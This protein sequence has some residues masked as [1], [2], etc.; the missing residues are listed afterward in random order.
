MAHCTPYAMRGDGL[1]VHLPWLTADERRVKQILSEADA[2]TGMVVSQ[3]AELPQ[4]Q[5]KEKA[6]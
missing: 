6:K 1:P 5:R 3:I 2:L 4:E